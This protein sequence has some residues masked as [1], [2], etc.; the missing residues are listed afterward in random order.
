MQTLVD[1]GRLTPEEARTDDRRV[2]IE[3]AVAA[4]APSAPDLAIH[5]V[6]PGDRLVLT[7]DGVHAVLEPGRLTD[8]LVAGGTPDEVVAAVRDAVRAAG[9]PDNHAMVVVDLHG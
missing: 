8:L 1:E 7:T 5:A 2:V 6:R 3:R 9:E 4:G